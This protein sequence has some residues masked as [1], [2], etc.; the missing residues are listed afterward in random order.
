MDRWVLEQGRIDCWGWELVNESQQVIAESSGAFGEL[1]KC[2]QDAEAHGYNGNS[3]ADTFRAVSYVI[4]W[5]FGTPIWV[6]AGA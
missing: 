2:V 3:R 4:T 5:F 6:S 1:E